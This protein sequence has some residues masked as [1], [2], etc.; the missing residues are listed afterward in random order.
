MVRRTLL[1]V[2][3]PAV[4]GEQVEL[5]TCCTGFGRSWAERRTSIRSPHG[6]TIDAVSLW[7]QIDVTTGRP[8]RLGEEFTRIYGAAAAGRHVSSKT[9]LPNRPPQDAVVEGPWRFRRADLDQFGHVNNAA[10]LA[11]AEERLVPGARRGTF[12]IEYLGAAD[13]DT[14]YDVVVSNGSVWLVPAGAPSP[15]TVFAASP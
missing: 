12:E 14:S 8:A 5:T 4:A 3:E 13:V 6:G 7:V 10:Q 2:T 15:V 1:R 9:S 11:V